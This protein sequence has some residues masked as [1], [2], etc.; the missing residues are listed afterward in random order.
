[1]GLFSADKPPPVGTIDD[2]QW[3]DLQRRAARANPE[4]A[5]TFSAA[6]TKS[7]LA[8]AEQYDKREQS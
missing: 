2:E 3:R 8:A 5:D 1:M 7:R 4:L 6:A